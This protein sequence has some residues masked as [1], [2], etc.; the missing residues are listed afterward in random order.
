MRWRMVRHRFVLSIFKI[1][2]GGTMTTDN[3]QLP[4]IATKIDDPVVE[5]LRFDA[6]QA[7]GGGVLLIAG[8]VA[9]SLFL[10]I[11][12]AGIV[13]W[14]S[15]G[16]LNFWLCYFIA[17]LILIPYI[18]KKI[19]EPQL[20]YV[21]ESITD[22]NDG[23][24]ELKGAHIQNAHHAAKMVLDWI[25]MGP[26][27]I[28]EGIKQMQGT[29]SNK[30]DRLFNRCSMLLRDLAR[31]GIA[32]PTHMLVKENETTE[33]LVQVIKYLDRY[34]WIGASS[35]HKRAWLS[36]KSKAELPRLGVVIKNP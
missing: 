34:D 29:Q 24:Y 20:P 6:Q 35:D 17:V 19:R 14:A 21:N 31:I 10:M 13:A 27:L 23:Y 7:T 11:F 3:N 16:Y 25:L 36:S 4:P 33:Q 15:Q 26:F 32:T 1:N 12:P 9:L 22:F 30:N 8:G 18:I 28:I 5:R 2:Y